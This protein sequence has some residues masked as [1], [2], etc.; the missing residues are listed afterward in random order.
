MVR[1]RIAR[2][3]FLGL[4][5]KFILMFTMGRLDRDKPCEKVCCK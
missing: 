3:C 4:K 1:R 2:K 5:T